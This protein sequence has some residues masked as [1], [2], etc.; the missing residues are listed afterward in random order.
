MK[1]L[2]II[3]QRPDEF[4]GAEKFL[5]RLVNTLSADRKLEVT[6][7]SGLSKGRHSWKFKS[8]QNQIPIKTLP[9]IFGRTARIVFFYFQVGWVI[10]RNRFDL[11]QSHERVP[12]C[13]IYRAGDG[14]HK[15][16]LI[17]KSRTL[18]FVGR[19][20]LFVSP[21][22]RVVCYFERRLFES[23]RLK[24]VI[25][26]SEMVGREILY[27]YPKVA[28]R[29]VLIYNGIPS[30]YTSEIYNT[31]WRYEFGPRPT[32]KPERLNLLFLGS[33]Y[34]RKGLIT[35]LKALRGHNESVSL[36]VVGQDRK[37]AYYKKLA[38]KFGLESN[39][40]F[41]GP[42]PDPREFFF[43]TDVLVQ[44]SHYDPFP[45][46]VIEAM[47]FGMRLIVS[48]LCG[49]TDIIDNPR[50]IIDPLD[51]EKWRMRITELAREKRE[52]KV[53]RLDGK[54]DLRKFRN[55]YMLNEYSKLYNDLFE[56][57]LV[58]TDIRA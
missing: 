12:F 52:K 37:I 6:M 14:V 45:N 35:I 1:R 33:D 8:P 36:Y 21:F 50:D 2:A 24:V 27:H 29:I 3:R 58:K 41:C 4:G 48:S 53:A 23:T 20:L 9:K 5:S 49:A 42:T 40:F 38:T 7:I 39:V 34:N 57:Y 31:N 54:Y 16:W 56:N 11:V 25:V 26:N 13:D 30:G 46:S 10:N 28:A 43:L 15:Q 18:G 47:A 55:E 22:H 17:N 19:F 51:V 44:P 32:S